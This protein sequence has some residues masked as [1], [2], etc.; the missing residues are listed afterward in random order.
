MPQH[1]RRYNPS[2]V[3]RISVDYFPL[4]LIFSGFLS[5][6]LSLLYARTHT[7]THKK[8]EVIDILEQLSISFH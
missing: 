3:G 8:A 5:S 2:G 1:A 4:L 7:H 6:F